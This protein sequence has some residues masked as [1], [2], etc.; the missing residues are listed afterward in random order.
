MVLSGD[1]SCGILQDDAE[2]SVPNDVGC[3]RLEYGGVEWCL[4]VQNGPGC[5]G[6]ALDGVK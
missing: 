6:M 2:W 1:E 5:C 3:R 4:V